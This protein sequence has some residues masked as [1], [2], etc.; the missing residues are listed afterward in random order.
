MCSV[1][2][3]VCCER[4]KSPREQ[5]VSPE[6]PA[7]RVKSW[8]VSEGWQYNGGPPCDKK[9]KSPVKK[10]LGISRRWEQSIKLSVGSFWACGP[11]PLP[12]LHGLEAGLACRYWAW[13]VTWGISNIG[14]CSIAMCW[15][16]SHRV[17]PWD[18]NRWQQPATKRSFSHHQQGPW[19]YS[20]VLV[21]RWP[22]R[23]HRCSRCD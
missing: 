7:T 19:W 11:G 23:I 16:W 2:C 8:A 10:C 18:Q 5:R 15:G 13:W 12:W 20:T 1:Q 21:G 3:T 6:A 22:G 17:K 14:T 4:L 9:I